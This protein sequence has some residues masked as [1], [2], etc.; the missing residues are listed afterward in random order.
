MM[1]GSADGA[2]MGVERDE[3]AWRVFVACIG[4]EDGEEEGASTSGGES[5]LFDTVK[6]ARG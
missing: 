4:G 6:V 3:S 5:T 2:V 1:E